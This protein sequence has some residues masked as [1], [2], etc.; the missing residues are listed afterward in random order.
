MSLLMGLVSSCT[1]VPP[2]SMS[3]PHWLGICFPLFTIAA[4]RERRHGRTPKCITVILT[5]ILYFAS[6]STSTSTYCIR[7][8]CSKETPPVRT[9]QNTVSH[10]CKGGTCLTWDMHFTHTLLTLTQSSKFSWSYSEMSS[11]PPSA[12][13][14]P[15]FYCNTEAVSWLPLRL[16][17]DDCANVVRMSKS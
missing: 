10:A 11:E 4:M 17:R 6:T 2:A 14:D 5:L 7:Y 13:L 16:I 1:K 12:S 9:S 3:T 15:Y 8:I